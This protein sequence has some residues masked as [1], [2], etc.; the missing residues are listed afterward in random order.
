MPDTEHAD[1]KN[2]K[3]QDSEQQYRGT[4]KP[5]DTAIRI[6]RQAIHVF[7]LRL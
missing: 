1:E 5:R 6:T 2:S 4:P 3:I 7:F